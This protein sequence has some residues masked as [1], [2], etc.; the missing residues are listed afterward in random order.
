VAVVVLAVGAVTRLNL[1]YVGSWAAAIVIAF[2]LPVAAAGIHGMQTYRAA[3]RDFSNGL[4]AAVRTYVSRDDILLALPK[5]GYRLTAKEPIY[6]VAAAGGHGGDTVVN[7]HSARRKA[8]V[9]FFDGDTSPDEA[10]AIVDRWD[11]Q[12]VLVRK[13][14]PQWSWPRQYLDQFDPVYEDRR[15]TLYPVD[16]AILP[17]V[18]A[19]KRESGTS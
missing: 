18:E 1:R 7:Q 17:R 2:V 8:A 3:P 5:V 9:D 10:Q 15:Y 19:L 14:F 6:I 11:V 4:L 12:W 13:D 16:P